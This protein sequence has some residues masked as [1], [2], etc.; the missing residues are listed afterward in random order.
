MA[1]DLVKLLERYVPKAEHD[2]ALDMINQVTEDNTKLAA[3]VKRLSARQT[4]HATKSNRAA[5]DALIKESRVNPDFAD[6]VFE[7]SGLA[8]EKDEIELEAMKGKL[9]PFLEAKPKFLAKEAPAP[10]PKQQQQPTKSNAEPSAKPTEADKISEAD[11]KFHYKSSNLSDPDWLLV[12]GDNY[13]AAAIAGNTH[14]IS[15]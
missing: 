7:L 6:E 3:E 14:R 15:D 13:A 5:Y 8:G 9:Q 4:E 11:G 10:K 2:Q 12:H 1:D